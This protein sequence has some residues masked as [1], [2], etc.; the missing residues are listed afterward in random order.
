MTSIFLQSTQAVGEF[1]LGAVHDT[2]DATAAG[3]G[4]IPGQVYDATKYAL[5]VDRF[6][7]ENRPW[8]KIGTGYQ[9]DFLDGDNGLNRFAER[10]NHTVLSVALGGVNTVT[11]GLTYELVNRKLGIDCPYFFP[12]P[13]NAREMGRFFSSG[14]IMMLTGRQILT[15]LKPGVAATA[16][17]GIDPIPMMVERPPLLNSDPIAYSPD[18]L[19][20]L[21]YQSPLPIKGPIQLQW[22]DP[23]RVVS[24]GPVRLQYAVPDAVEG[25]VAHVRRG[26][27]VAP[28]IL[29]QM[30]NVRTPTLIDPVARAT[31]ELL[32]DGHLQVHLLEGII[33]D[34]H[35]RTAFLFQY[36]NEMRVGSPHLKALW[37]HLKLDEYEVEFLANG[38][39]QLV[40]VYTPVE[41]VPTHRSTVPMGAPI[42]D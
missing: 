3:I 31:I 8:F 35:P 21:A 39:T 28:R 33:W 7:G 20:V 13:T 23:I 25:V 2:L 19:R 34:A 4:A 38:D 40:P 12:G 26:N 9:G 15:A 30:L 41:A 27:V 17:V 37:R 32:R 24:Q 22:M 36:L 18:H 6:V 29:R 1:L 16:S 5:G 42:F 11:G 14:M 10:F